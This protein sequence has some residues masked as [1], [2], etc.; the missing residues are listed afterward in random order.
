M[1]RPS[2]ADSIDASHDLQ[3]RLNT[4]TST[5]T[6]IPPTNLP[7]IINN[8]ATTDDLAHNNLNASLFSSTSTRLIQHQSLPTTLADKTTSTIHLLSRQQLNNNSII[9]LRDLY[10]FF[11][12][13][14]LFILYLDDDIT[15]LSLSSLSL[16]FLTLVSSFLL[17]RI[18]ACVFSPLVGQFRV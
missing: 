2:P 7:L 6:S 4:I 8:H 3:Q 18:K 10:K 12:S 5:T 15:Y 9:L 11:M 13:F 16:L 1:P 14:F 17:A